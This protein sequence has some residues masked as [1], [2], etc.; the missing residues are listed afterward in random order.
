M[1]LG[2]GMSWEGGLAWWVR[3][4]LVGVQ[5]DADK[6][7]VVARTEPVA[8]DEIPSF[9]PVASVPSVVIWTSVSVSASAFLS[10]VSWGHGI[11]TKGTAPYAATSCDVCG[12]GGIRTTPGVL[13][14]PGMGMALACSA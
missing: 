4:A 2:D 5:H 6:M 13:G 14:P 11:E 7:L 10:P 1:G 8:T 3:P 9:S 12:I